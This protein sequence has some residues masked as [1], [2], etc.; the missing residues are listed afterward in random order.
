MVKETLKAG[1]KPTKAQ[2][3]EIRAAEKRDITYTDDAPRLTDEE[4]AEFK[5]INAENR[6]KI[7]C[8]LRLS[9][10]SLDWWKSFGDG[11]TSAMA[12]MLEDAKNYPEIIKKII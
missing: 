12:R 1:Q 11:Y 5:Q 2:I 3:E 10:Q 8:T 4:L 6:K 7:P 9:K